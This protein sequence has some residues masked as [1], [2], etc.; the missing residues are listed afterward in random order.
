[1]DEIIRLQNTNQMVLV[2]FPLR[3]IQGTIRRFLE[4]ESINGLQTASPSFLDL[5]VKDAGC[6]YSGN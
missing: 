6:K 5:A 1:M 4:G 2:S 3:T